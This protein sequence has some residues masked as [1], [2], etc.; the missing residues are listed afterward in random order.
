MASSLAVIAT[1]VGGIPEL[2]RNGENGILVPAADPVALSQA[3]QRLADTPEQ[4]F[5]MGQLGRARLE[6]QFTLERKISETEELC[7]SLIRR[8]GPVSRAAHA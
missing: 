5:A 4:C 8:P 1:N 3:L 2:I 7:I 6:K